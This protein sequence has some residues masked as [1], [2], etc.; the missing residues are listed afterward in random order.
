MY[1]GSFNPWHR[2]HQDILDKAY[3][4]FDDVHV[5]KYGVDFTG[6]LNDY[7]KDKQY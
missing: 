5:A 7:L 6:L 3:K 4:I 2:G 1:P